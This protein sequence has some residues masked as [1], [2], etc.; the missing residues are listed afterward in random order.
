LFIGAVPQPPTITEEDT[1]RKEDLPQ[2]PIIFVAGETI[3]RAVDIKTLQ[4][5]TT[6]LVT[7][8]RCTKLSDNLLK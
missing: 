8:I 2:C 3:Y 6:F 5:L 7:N 4:I 1:G